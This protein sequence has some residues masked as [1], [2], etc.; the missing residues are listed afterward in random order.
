[1]S[2]SPE[3]MATHAEKFGRT[4]MAIDLREKDR[5]RGPNRELAQRHGSR[6]S[7]P[8]LQSNGKMNLIGGSPDVPVTI[9]FV[10]RSRNCGCGT[11]NG[12]GPAHRGFRRRTQSTGR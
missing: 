12:F 3:S 2:F 11:S 5:M 6:L 8:E 10:D 1:M 4:V 9:L 7:S